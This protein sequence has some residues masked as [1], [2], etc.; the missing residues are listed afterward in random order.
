MTDAPDKQRRSVAALQ[1]FLDW[2]LEQPGLHPAT[3]QAIK[4]AWH[5]VPET[6]GISGDTDVADLRPDLLMNDFE[7][8]RG[9]NFRSGPTYR[10]RLRVGQQLF[11]GWH[12]GDPSWIEVARTKRPRPARSLNS[13]RTGH[14]GILVRDFPLRRD[15]TISF[16]LPIDLTATEAN[17]IAAFIA[18]HVIEGGED[19]QALRDEH[20]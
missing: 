15:L 12:A 10:T 6:L 19:D 13:I 4:S 2:A 14:E 5:S 20:D 18:S 9:P 11:L 3:I 1:T 8:V 17:R 16:E 7:K